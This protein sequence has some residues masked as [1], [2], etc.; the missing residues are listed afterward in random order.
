MLRPE[1]FNDV[2]WP[3]MLVMANLVV[4]FPAA[5]RWLKRFLL[6]YGGRG[7]GK[8]RAVA[9]ALVILMLVGRYR[10][11]LVRKVFDT[12]R[13]SQ[14]QE[15]R[16]VLDGWGL[17]RY[18]AYTVTPLKITCK[19]TGSTCIAKG[20]DKAEKIKSLASIDVVG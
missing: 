7:S 2:Y 3:L 9:Q 8:S 11:A 17:D 4:K 14:L 6:L 15:I 13:D 10:I 19:R 18:F 12:I 20:F 1:L 5:S 16:D